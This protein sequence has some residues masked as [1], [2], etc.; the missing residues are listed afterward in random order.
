MT[1][2]LGRGTTEWSPLVS[3]GC[4]GI[5]GEVAIL[6]DAVVLEVGQPRTASAGVK[7]G[8]PVEIR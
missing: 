2:Q 6:Q 8:V 5:H 3:R 7:G 1:S 4:S